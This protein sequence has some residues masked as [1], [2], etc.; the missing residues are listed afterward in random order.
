ME[1][2]KVERAGLWLLKA[3]TGAFV[4]LL[5]G[6]H[7]VVNHLV[8]PGGLLTYEDVLRYF[9]NPFIPVMEVVFL[10]L[11]VSHAL[12]GLRGILLDLN[13]PM[14]VRRG[15]DAGLVVLG[16]AAVGYGI[17]LAWVIAQRGA[18]IGLFYSIGLV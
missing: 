1:T 10:V 14:R 4:I 6:V 13:L 11:V 5:L 8:M 9:A 12:I 3:G 2:R 17:W 16:L 7:L 18:Q 15:V